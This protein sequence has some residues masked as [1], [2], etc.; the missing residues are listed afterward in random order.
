MCK[1]GVGIIFCTE[2]PFVVQSVSVLP[3]HI[4]FFSLL[5]LINDVVFPLDH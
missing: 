5:L 1:N 2:I 3:S 4:F